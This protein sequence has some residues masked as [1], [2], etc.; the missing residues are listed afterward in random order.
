MMAVILSI[1]SARTRRFAASSGVSANGIPHADVALQFRFA[2]FSPLIN[3]AKRA[4][5]VSISR[6]AVVCVFFWYFSSQLAPM[7]RNRESWTIFNPSYFCSKPKCVF[8]RLCQSKRF[9]T[10]IRCKA[11]AVFSPQ[12]SHDVQQLCLA[13]RA[14]GADRA[15]AMRR[16]TASKNNAGVA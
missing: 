11:L 3:C 9:P 5:A 16:K 6:F 8:M 2:H 1:N 14:D 7:H 13:A 15:A 10:R 12:L 4:F